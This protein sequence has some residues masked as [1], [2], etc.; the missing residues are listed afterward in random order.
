MKIITQSVHFTADQ[1]L[2]K[3]IDH[4]ISSLENY[5]HQIIQA[6]VYLK[7]ENSGQIKEKTV[8]VK[9][10]VPGDTIFISE[11]QLKF[12]A[13]VDAVSDKLKRRV[14]KYKQQLRSR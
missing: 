8:E 6:E 2:L 10:Q 5:F 9:L 1:K 7:L 12:E 11:K 3:Y 13:A 4:K 14:I